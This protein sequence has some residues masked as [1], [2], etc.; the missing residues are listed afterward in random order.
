VFCEGFEDYG[1]GA[2]PG[3]NVW[4]RQSQTLVVGSQRVARGQR[5]LHVPDMVS[6]ERFIRTTKP[7]PMLGNRMYGRLFVWIEKE[8][9]EKPASVYHWT[10]AEASERPQ[11]GALV[12]RAVGGLMFNV[13][14]NR[15]LFNIETHGSGETARTDGS[16][17]VM[18][19][20]WHCFEWMLDRQGNQFRFWWNGQERPGLAWPQPGRTPEAK[21]NFPEMKA[22]SIGWAEYQV[23]RT[24]WE[25]WLDELALHTDRVGCDR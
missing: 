14:D 12:L 7:F 11:G 23:T 3:M 25:I 4:V 17:R 6:G 16:S 18:P 19:R 5:A 20:R 9:Q 15:L 10:A 24:P 13:G 21:Y 2:A 22:F 1:D 8:P